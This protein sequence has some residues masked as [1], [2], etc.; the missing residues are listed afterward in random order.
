MSFFEKYRDHSLIAKIMAYTLFFDAGTSVLGMF[1]KMI[2]YEYYS[3]SIWTILYQAVP[4]VA[5][6]I[7]FLDKHHDKT[8]KLGFAGTYVAI[9][10][11]AMI[12]TIASGN[13]SFIYILTNFL[14]LVFAAAFALYYLGVI[15]PAG[16][17]VFFMVMYG[18]TGLSALFTIF[19]H[20]IPSV[21]T[22]A[23]CAVLAMY[24]YQETRAANPTVVYAGMIGTAYFV[25]YTVLSSLLGMFS[26]YLPSF[27]GHMNIVFCLAMPL[28][29]F[30]RIVPG[31][32]QPF[33]F[34]FGAIT[35]QAAQPPVQQYAQPMQ[36]NGFAPQ[37]PVQQP[38]QPA[39]P[40]QQN[41]DPMT[42]QPLNPQPQ[43]QNNFDPMTGQPLNPQPQQNRFDPM[44]GQ[45]LDPNNGQ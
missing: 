2:R 25:V 5:G 20:S 4:V 9:R 28:L 31:E 22:F 44:T 40:M 8:F 32:G 38:V 35:G 19:G 13:P 41:F 1:I 45:P 17:N 6:L 3:F 18:I 34:D 43:Q 11:I 24:G 36:Q 39:Q 37:Q 33:A 27:F 21:S 12:R 10:L 26:V 15:R 16:R 23:M 30:D 42:G 29:V 7:F 14:S